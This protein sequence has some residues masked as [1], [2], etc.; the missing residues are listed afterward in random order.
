MIGSPNLGRPLNYNIFNLVICFKKTFLV[1]KFK[2]VNIFIGLFIIFYYY[3]NLYS[4]Y[5]EDIL[6]NFLKILLTTKTENNVILLKQ[7]DVNFIR[8]TSLVII[9]TV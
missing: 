5:F 7:V 3:E 4:L 6:N 1:V 2:V 9:S 8:Y